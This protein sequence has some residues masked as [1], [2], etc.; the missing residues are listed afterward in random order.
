MS[1]LVAFLPMTIY[2][3]VNNIVDSVNMHL[4]ELGYTGP[5]SFSLALLSQCQT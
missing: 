1:G 5:G 2:Q 4:F 3:D